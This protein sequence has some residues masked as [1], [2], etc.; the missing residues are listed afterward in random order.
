VNGAKV[1][2]YGIPDGTGRLDAY[3]INLFN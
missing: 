1:R 3:C 2:V